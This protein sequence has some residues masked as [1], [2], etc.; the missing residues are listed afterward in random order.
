VYPPSGELIT[1]VQ[2]LPCE[3]EIV[4]EGWLAACALNAATRTL[5]AVTALPNVK[6]IGDAP[7]LAVTTP[8]WSLVKPTL[9]L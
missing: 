2:V 8:L 3:S 1:E 4:A 9:S 6:V 7:P 5:P